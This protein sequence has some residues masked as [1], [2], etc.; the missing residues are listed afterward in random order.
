[1]FCYYHRLLRRSVQGSV[2][3]SSCFENSFAHYFFLIL[4]YVEPLRGSDNHISFFVSGF[5]LVLLTFYPF[6]VKY[7]NKKLF[8]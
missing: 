3:Y 6:R 8:L 5:H 7:A 1:M 2:L 4:L